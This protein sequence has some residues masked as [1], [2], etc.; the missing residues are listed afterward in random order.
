MPDFVDIVIN[1]TPIYIDITQTQS[2][3]IDINLGGQSVTSVNGNTGTVVLNQ[4]DIRRV[5]TITTSSTPTINCDTTDELEITAAASA[6]VFT[7]TGTPY[8]GQKIL[9]RYKDNGNSRALSVTS[10]F[11]DL[12]GIP[13]ATTVG[14]V[15]AWFA[16]YSANR[17]KWE[18]L[19]TVTEP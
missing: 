8:P 19:A 17:S 3:Y 15:G 5:T 7:V 14:K 6:M 18:I 16:R 13:V 10:D 2:V 1:E 12:V 9:Y 4:N 11:V